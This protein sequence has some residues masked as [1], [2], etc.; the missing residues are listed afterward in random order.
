MAGYP[1]DDRS[2]S[3]QRIEEQAPVSSRW[4]GEIFPQ[5]YEL[6]AEGLSS[7]SLSELGRA[8]LAEE[9]T[10]CLRVAVAADLFVSSGQS[11][12]GVVIG[13]LPRTGS[14]FLQS[15]L[16]DVVPFRVLRGYEAFDP[17]TVLAGQPEVARKRARQRFDAARSVAPRLDLLHPL[18]ADGPEECTPLLQHTFECLQWAMMMDCPSYCDWLIGSSRRHAYRLWLSQLRMIDAKARWWILKSPMHMCDYP[19]LFEAAP[20]LRLVQV[21][22]SVIDIVASFL[23][24][25]L[26]ARRVFEE[27]KSAIEL[28]TRLGPFWLPRLARLL[29]RAE[30]DLERMAMHVV[31]VDFERLMAQPNRVVAEIVEEL[32]L[33]RGSGGPLRRTDHAQRPVHPSLDQ[34]GVDQAMVRHM[35]RDHINGSFLLP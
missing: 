23:D 17:V 6:L 32:E 20:G 35:L 8:G 10:H 34:F 30:A 1:S 4:E 28:G 5:L 31:V 18:D 2:A 22:R 24:L 25:C 27:P 29:D 7:P 19:S 14:T 16:S 12:E 33:P 13:G 11:P 3:F 21:R 9:F 15:A 26:E